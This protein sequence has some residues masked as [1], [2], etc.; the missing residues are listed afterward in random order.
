MPLA[1]DILNVRHQPQAE[2][3]HLLIWIASENAAP[4]AH[5]HA[6]TRSPHKEAG[7]E[8]VEPDIQEVED[9][10]QTSNDYPRTPN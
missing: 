10:K 9:H 2:L 3:F 7:C 5:D 8:R 4:K 1:R 6:P